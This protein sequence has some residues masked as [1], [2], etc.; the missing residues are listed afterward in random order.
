M[1]R[2][3]PTYRDLHGTQGSALLTQQCPSGFIPAAVSISDVSPIW[4]GEDREK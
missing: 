1:A 2:Q 3:V 4:I